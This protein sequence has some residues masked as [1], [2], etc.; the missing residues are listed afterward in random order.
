MMKYPMIRILPMSK[1]KVF[2]NKTIEVVQNDFFLQDLPYRQEYGCKVGC[3]FWYKNSVMNA[4]PNTLV[5]FQYDGK[6]IALAK[7]ISIPQS[8]PKPQYWLEGVVPRDWREGDGDDKYKGT[9]C[10]ERDSINI[11]DP[12]LDR[13]DIQSVWSEG[14]TDRFGKWH[15]GFEKFGRSPLFLDPDKYQEFYDRFGNRIRTRTD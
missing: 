8:F 12:P 13:N 6:I 1:E 15:P 3:H 7:L 14:F 2:E 11:F 5:L 4:V 9:Y 10:F